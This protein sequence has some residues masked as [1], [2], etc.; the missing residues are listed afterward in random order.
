MFCASLPT[1][2]N[3]EQ[4]VDENAGLPCALITCLD[5]V[6]RASVEVIGHLEVHQLD[7]V[8][9]LSGGRDFLHLLFGLTGYCQS[10]D[11]LVERR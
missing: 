10:L 8:Y 6:R 11:F 7:L 1:L 4:S 2:Q 3:I 9:F 5:L